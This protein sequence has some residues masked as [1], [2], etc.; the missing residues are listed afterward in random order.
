MKKQLALILML[1]FTTLM[2]AQK[3]KVA[4]GGFDFLKGQSEVNVEF[5]Y[6]NM[7]IFKD[8]KTN[9]QYMAQRSKKLSEKSKGK[10]KTWEKKWMASRDLIYA[11]KFLELMNRYLEEDEGVRFDEGIEGTKY[12]L[13]VD[14]VWLY[15]GYNVGVMKKGAKVSTVL[16]FVETDNRDNVLLEVTSKHAPGERFGGTYSN[17]D[18]IGEG[19]AKTGKSFAKLLL[20]KAF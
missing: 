12:T 13:I 16:R 5:V 9:E 8:N 3:L 19:Y 7:K 4:S 1:C 2:V 20:K 6:D 17:E 10:G 15:P 11:P 14:T 18:R